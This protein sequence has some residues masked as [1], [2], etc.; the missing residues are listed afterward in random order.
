MYVFCRGSYESLGHLKGALDVH[1]H[2]YR[3]PSDYLHGGHQLICMGAI[4]LFAWGPSDY[5]H[6]GHQI[7]CM[8]AISLFAWGPSDYLHGGHQIIKGAD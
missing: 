1:I 7:I 2:V 4:S 8:G 3:G 5:L 6:G